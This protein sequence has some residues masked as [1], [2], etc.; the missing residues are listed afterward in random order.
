MAAKADRLPVPGIVLGAYPER[1]VA[2]KGA[3][4]AAADCMRALLPRRAESRYSP[5]LERV[6]S[7]FA[8]VKRVCARELG[9]TLYPTQLI[10]ARI[11]LDKQLAEMATG[12][13]KT[14]A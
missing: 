12:E 5:F 13:G 8:L 1:P 14:L 10:A 2:T 3:L 11:M 4:E 9:L 6:A 7:A